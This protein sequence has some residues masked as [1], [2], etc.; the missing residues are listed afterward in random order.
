VK[1]DGFDG[2]LGRRVTRR[3]AAAIL[4]WVV[5]FLLTLTTYSFTDD[6][7][8]RLSRARQIVHYGELPFRDFFD[9]GYFLT[10]F[11]SA[12]L[13]RLTGGNLLGEML[14]TSAF[15]AAG[16]AI[17][18]LLV[19]RVAPSGVSAAV[20]TALVILSSPRPYDFDKFF[21]Y[22][23]GILLCWRYI[24]RRTVRSLA[25]LA[26]SAV[27]AGM[28]RYDN[29]L[30]IATGALAAIAAVHSPE[31]A[32]MIR[33]AGV[34]AAACVVCAVPYLVCLQ[35]SGGVVEAAEQMMDYA[36]REGARTQI[37]E[38]PTAMFSDLRMKPLPPP[39]PD[40]IQIR[41]T[42]EADEERQQLEA[43]YR[44]HDGV[45][46][47]DPDERTWLYEIDDASRG[48]LR[49]LID[50]ARVADTHGVD[51]ATA[52]LTSQEPWTRRVHRTIP[53]LRNWDMA[54]SA[55]GAAGLL[56]Y[57]Y[58][59]VPLVA[60][61]VALT[62]RMESAERARVLSAAA[63]ALPVAVFILRDPIVARLGGAVGPVAVVGTWL[64][65]HIHKSWAARVIAVAVIAT[66]FVAT[67]F[68]VEPSRLRRVLE[69]ASTSPPSPALVLERQEARLVEYLRRCTQPDDRIFA[70][71]FAP[72]LY[73]FS[74][75]GFAGG[76]VVTFG[77]HWSEP[78]RQRR[79]VAKLKTESVPVVIFEDD[80]SEFRALYP[81]VREY[82]RANYQ[83]AGSIE[84]YN[85]LTRN[86]S[87]VP[88]CQG[89]G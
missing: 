85:V 14:G 29:G 37:F 45:A 59:G 24:D 53:L 32:T 7:F 36:R 88:G 34:F 6:H 66:A 82:L 84:S 87:S 81:V 63:V 46:R 15:I 48:N 21:F 56:Y 5:A 67:G 4:L 86:G 31:P 8:D 10:E 42:P 55:S 64:W 19:R 41:W 23:L 35:L 18:M 17:V 52:Q 2:I 27:V 61:A 11:L 58:V 12:A 44:L 83:S 65:G 30:F 57:V 39:P 38:I 40:R 16:A 71:W 22:P 78:D 54:W 50:D 28:F 33:R 43:R 47:S 1:A 20:I 80:G 77:G 13:Q 72:Q 75:R 49:A 3:S 70:A 51:R 9:P 74:G 76:M 26:G 89:A 73:F 79:I 68:N 25:W 60:V 62:R 69:Q